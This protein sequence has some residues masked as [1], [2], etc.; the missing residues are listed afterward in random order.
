[1]FV[2][3]SV[4]SNVYNLVLA[5]TRRRNSHMRTN[6]V[7][8]EKLM[9]EALRLTGAPSKRRVV[10][11]SLRLMIQVRRQERIRSL[12]GKLKWTAN[13]DAMRRDV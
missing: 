5:Y 2:L 1:M 8:D 13:L 6:I 4:A 9:A 12:R 11:E 7:I 3:H 10:E